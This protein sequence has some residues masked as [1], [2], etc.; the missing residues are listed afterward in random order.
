MAVSPPV[1]PIWTT[2]YNHPVPWQTAFQPMRLD[3]MLAASAQRAPEAPCLDFYGRQF[4]YKEVDQLVSRFAAGLQGLGLGKGHKLGLFL[5]NCPHYVIAYYAASRAGLTLVNFS[6]LYTEEELA[7]Q[8]ADSGVETMVCLDIAHLYPTIDAVLH[9]GRLQ[10]LIIGSIAEMLPWPKNWAY[11][12]FKR[13]MAA[14]WEKDSHHLHFADLLGEA[15]ALQPVAVDA[16]K[17]VAL[18]QYTGGTTGTPKG[19]V[20]THAN[21]SINAQQVRALENNPQRVDRILGAL[22]FFHVFANTTVLNRTILNG[23]LI[24]MLPK[25]EVKEALATIKR[26]KVTEFPGV[27]TMFQA[28]LD[29]PAFD[30][31]MLESVSMCISG[32]APMSA[33]LRALFAKA[34][35]AIIIEGYGLTESAGVVAVNPYGG[36]QKAGS[37]GQPIAGTDVVIVDPDNPHQI[38]PQGAH[39]EITVAGPQIMRGYW[40]RPQSDAGAFI[41]GRLRTGDV[42]YID[43]D[44]FIFIVDRIKDLILVGGFNVYPST[45][46]TELMTHPAVKEAIVIGVPDHYLGERPKAF[47]TLHS[48]AETSAEELLAFLNAHVGKHE[49]AV[50]VEIRDTLPKTMIGKLSRKALVDEE[51]AKAAART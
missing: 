47:V 32:G 22:P 1:L 26:A 25:F 29:H 33:E 49:R 45:L 42:G 19:A 9:H 39:G 4:S 24:V 43:A 37:I 34:A 2:H 17:D 38:L 3:A 15:Q 46:E 10:R 8:V 27:P 6:P 16:E 13:E 11:R 35:D 5:P 18:L 12:I 40:Q 51:K 20:L 50:A 48:G 31:A 21:L 28:I 36:P 41:D 7:H 30:P 44:G 14:R 23:G